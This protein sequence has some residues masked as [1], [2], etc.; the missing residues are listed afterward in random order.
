MAQHEKFSNKLSAV[1][2]AAGCSVGLGN[3]WRFPYVVG[4]NGGGAFFLVYII[5][6]IIIG[7]PVMISEFAVGRSTGVGAVPAY[8]KLGGK[9]WM[10]LGYNS[11]ITSTLIMGF[12]YVVA[13][14]TAEYFWLSVTG[15]LANY[16]TAAEYKELFGT[17]VT[18]PWKPIF[19]TWI[20]IAANHLVIQRG[21]TKGLEKVSNLL[22]PLFFVIL[23]VMAIN[24]LMM[25]NAMEGV[26]FFLQPDITKITPSVILKGVG[27]AFFS[28]SIGLGA[29]VIYGAY[30]PKSNNLRTTALQVSFLDTIVAVIAGLI[31][32]PATAS[33]GI[34]PTAGPA[35]VFETLPMIFQQLPWSM[36]WATIF[37]L[38]LMIAAI[39]STMSLHEVGTVFLMEKFHISRTKGTAAVSIIIGLLAALASLSLGVGSEMKILG[40]T[41]FDLLDYVTA[42]I[43]LPLG[44]MLTS[45]FVGWKMEESLLKNELTNNGELK[46]G[47]YREVIFMLRYICP[48]IIFFIFLDSIGLFTV[49]GF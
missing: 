3:I 18:D 27:Q 11:I 15:D 1:L 19:Y 16:T 48:I 12:Y 46:F 7:L 31:I 13:G 9:R 21:V 43:T 17:F 20:F 44:G 40:L 47:Y 45:I 49:L 10:L 14:W 30:M 41:L 29:L 6:I 25:P 4:E 2:V 28:L 32:F 35:L 26:K 5:A 23:I 8:K 38:L 42:N 37:F 39:T 33:T 34:D 22:M 36:L 24:S